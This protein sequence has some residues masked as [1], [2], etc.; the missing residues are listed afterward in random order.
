MRNL[1]IGQK[2]FAMISIM[3]LALIV[4][5]I[6][7]WNVATGAT[8]WNML[9]VALS[10]LIAGGWWSAVV[11]RGLTRTLGGDPEQ[12]RMAADAITAG[13][14]ATQIPVAAGDSGSLMAAM[15]RMSESLRR[16]V[17]DLRVGVDAVGTASVEIAQGNRD[18]SARTEQQAS[19]L[20]QTAAS[21]EQMTATVK[22]N[23]DNARQANQLAA[24]AS[25]VAAKGGA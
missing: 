4:V 9:G 23:A 3:A 12:A 17:G 10:A 25:E 1:T 6:M 19:S 5:T 14:L 18:L 13:D 20:Q 2:L 11:I 15:Q 21:M 7:G 24:S 22:T 16:V 8:R